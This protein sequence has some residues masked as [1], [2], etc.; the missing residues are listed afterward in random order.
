MTKTELQPDHNNLDAPS[1]FI[2][3][4]GS[5]DEGDVATAVFDGPDT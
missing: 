2:S 1:P 3:P 5:A 4:D